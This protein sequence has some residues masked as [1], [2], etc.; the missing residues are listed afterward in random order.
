LG[1]ESSTNRSQLQV[2]VINIILIEKKQRL[3]KQQRWQ[4]SWGEH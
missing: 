3:H 4:R 2:I 1:D